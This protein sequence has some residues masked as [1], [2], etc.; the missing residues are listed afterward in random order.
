MYTHICRLKR[1]S[2]FLGTSTSIVFVYTRAHTHTSC[3][4][5]SSSNVTVSSHSGHFERTPRSDG[6]DLERDKLAHDDEI[7]EEREEG[8]AWTRE[9]DS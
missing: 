6:D 4:N 3:I 9:N 5:L 8:E 7:K 1:E 2:L